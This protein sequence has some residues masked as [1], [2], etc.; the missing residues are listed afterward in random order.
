MVAMRSKCARSD[1][2][3]VADRVGSAGRRSRW[4]M[5]LWAASA[6][7]ALSVI[8]THDGRAEPAFNAVSELRH[9]LAGDDVRADFIVVLD[10]SGSMNFA[11]AAG[12]RRRVDPPGRRIDAFLAALPGLLEAVPDGDYFSLVA[13]NTRVIQDANLLIPRW[14]SA[15]SPARVMERLRREASLRP[16]PRGD[17]DIGRAIEAALQKLTRDDHAPIQFVFFVT[18]GQHDV[19]EDSSSPYRDAEGEAPWA[20][21][22]SSWRGMSSAPGR[23][24]TSYLVGMYDVADAGRIGGVI[25]D[26]SFLATASPEQLRAFFAEQRGRIEHE[27][28]KALVEFDMRRTTLD[29][30]RSVTAAEDFSGVPVGVPIS[31]RSNGNKLDLAVELLFHPKVVCF[32]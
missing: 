30:A 18:D 4:R 26:V 29:V 20:R 9:R 31:V 19:R 2:P 13:F 15:T 16:D 27:K 24:V 23:V 7:A 3:A 22:G 25:P 14:D 8:A 21:L 1:L 32:V 17:T 28:L 10:L 11:A 5:S 12:A 6:L